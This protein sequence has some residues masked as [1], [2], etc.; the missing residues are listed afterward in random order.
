MS[1]TPTETLIEAMEQVGEATQ[2]LVIL[3][4]E[5]GHILTLGSS[6]QRVIRFG[7]LETA[8]QW[9]IADMSAES[10]RES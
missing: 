4:T 10:Q 1:K 8:K 7:L 3:T 2:C 5:D 6:D 9:M